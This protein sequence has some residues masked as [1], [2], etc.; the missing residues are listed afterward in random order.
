MNQVDPGAGGQADGIDTGLGG[1]LKASEAAK[2]KNGDSCGARSRRPDGQ[3]A[4]AGCA[5][6]AW[7]PREVARRDSPPEQA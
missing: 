7:M 4:S 2:A 6:P 3:L 5:K 1:R